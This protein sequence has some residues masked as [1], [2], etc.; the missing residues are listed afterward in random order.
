[1][2]ASISIVLKST[3]TAIYSNRTALGVDDQDRA[4]KTIKG[5]VGKQL[6]YRNPNVTAATE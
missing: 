4:Y 1:M 5:T 6:T 3:C 2:K